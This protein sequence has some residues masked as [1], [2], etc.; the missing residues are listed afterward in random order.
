MKI[1]TLP[2]DE[3][4]ALTND[5]R[6]ELFWIGVGSAA[7]KQ[8]AQ[9]NFLIIKGDAHIRGFAGW[10]KQGVRYRFDRVAGEGRKKGRP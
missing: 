8:Q 6:L 1:E 5:G 3:K 10:T 9:S 4:L 7:S 2:T